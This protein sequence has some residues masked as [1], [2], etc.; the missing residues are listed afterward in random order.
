L[1]LVDTSV[2]IDFFAG[3]NN[4]C[5][6]VLRKAVEEGDDLCICGLILTETLQGIRSDKEFKHIE[7]ILSDLLYLPITKNLFMKSAEIYRQIRKH[8][9]TIRSPIDCMIASVC[10]EHEVVLLHHDR[11]FEVIKEYFPLQTIK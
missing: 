10:M 7:E 11:D 2:W 5:C 1:I 6:S 3:K 9:R 8:G 4:P